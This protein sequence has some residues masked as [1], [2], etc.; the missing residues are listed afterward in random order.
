MSNHCLHTELPWTTSVWRISVKNL[1]LISYC[2]E[3]VN[4]LSF[5]IA[6]RPEYKLLHRTVNCSLLFCTIRCYE[7][8]RVQQLA[9]WN[10]ISGPLLSNG[11]LLRLHHSG[12]QPSCR[13]INFATFFRVLL[14]VYDFASRSCDKAW[15][16]TSFS[17]LLLLEQLNSYQRGLT[18]ISYWTQCLFVRLYCVL[19]VYKW[20]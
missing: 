15:T 2:F 16:Y 8:S 20:A 14:A 10:M 19:H 12:C 17:L 11:C 9:T 1:G 5:I 18:E 4:Q 3:C 7:I 6:T 13:S